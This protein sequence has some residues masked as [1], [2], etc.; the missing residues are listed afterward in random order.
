MNYSKFFV[1]VIL[2]IFSSGSNSETFGES[3]SVKLAC[4][5]CGAL[6]DAR[7]IAENLQQENGK[8]K[9]ERERLRDKLISEQRRLASM[10]KDRNEYRTRL[11]RNTAILNENTHLLIKTTEFIETQKDEVER[12][13]LAAS[14]R[15]KLFWSMYES[16]AAKN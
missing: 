9:E 6:E 10:T 14:M 11:E 2:L 4:K 8:L 15:L 1:L 5:F 13:K 7:R 16:T 3:I 12:L